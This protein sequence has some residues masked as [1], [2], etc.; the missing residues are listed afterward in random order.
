MVEILGDL[1]AVG[2]I[3]SRLEMPND[4]NCM[5]DLIGPPLNVVLLQ[6]PRGLSQVFNH[7]FTEQDHEAYGAG[8]AYVGFAIGG[9]GSRH[10]YPVVDVPVAGV[11]L[12]EV[13]D[14]VE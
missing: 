14:V 9:A 5:V 1:S 12:V 8:A 2:K 11:V 10:S 4:Q 7:L 3:Q 13:V 6:R